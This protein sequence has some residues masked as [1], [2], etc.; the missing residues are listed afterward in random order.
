MGGSLA[1]TVGAALFSSWPVPSCPST[2]EPKAYAIMFANVSQ[3]ARA[4]TKLDN[5]CRRR[6]RIFF[7][8]VVRVG[9]E[10]DVGLDVESGSGLCARWRGAV[11]RGAALLFF[12]VG[13]FLVTWIDVHTTFF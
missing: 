9:N 1:M 4:E 13:V 12:L 5:E 11:R 6:R 8:D 3:L 10:R 2:L 7:V